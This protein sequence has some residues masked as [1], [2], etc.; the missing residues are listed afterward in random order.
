[1]HNTHALTRVSGLLPPG[2][3]EVLH[4]RITDRPI[5]VVSIQILAVLSFVIFGL[6]FS[7]LAISLGQLPSHMEFGLAETVAVLAAIV[8]TLVLHELIHGAGMQCFGAKPKYGALWKQLM[9][10]ATAPEFA[11]RRN[12]YV[13]VALAPI[14]V[15]SILVV[16]GMVLLQGA[17]WVALLA[18]CATFNASGAIGDLWITSIVLRYPMKAFVMDERDGIRVFLPTP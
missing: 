17:I 2:Y 12:N 3:Q 14:V 6:V 11:F 10:Y 15:I 9:F 5:R 16:L 1:M 7:S 4:W 8:L 18:I 13:V